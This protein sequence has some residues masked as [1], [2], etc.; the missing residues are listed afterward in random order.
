MNE[1]IYIVLSIHFA[2]YRFM[3]TNTKR[4]I[5]FEN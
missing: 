3:E 1:R 5:Q 4:L 2:F